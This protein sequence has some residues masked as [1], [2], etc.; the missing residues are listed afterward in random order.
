[1]VPESRHKKIALLL[2]SIHTG[3]SNELWSEIARLAKTSH[4]SLFVFPG[5]GLSVRR[6]KSIFAMPST[7]WSTPTMYKES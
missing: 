4:A 3:A 1:M 7:R 5:E 2:A 6:T